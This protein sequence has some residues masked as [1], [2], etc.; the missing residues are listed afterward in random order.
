MLYFIIQSSRRVS[1]SFFTGRGTVKERAMFKFNHFNFN[2][3]DIDKSLA[4]YDKAL[5]LKPLAKA[6]GVDR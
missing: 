1:N 3:L 4:F 6:E 2:V 5:G